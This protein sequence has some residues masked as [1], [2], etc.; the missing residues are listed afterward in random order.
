VNGFPRSELG[1]R[2]EKEAIDKSQCVIL[3]CLDNHQRQQQQQQLKSER[4]DLHHRSCCR[5]DC[6][7]SLINYEIAVTLRQDAKR[8]RRGTVCRLPRH[9]VRTTASKLRRVVFRQLGF[10]FIVQH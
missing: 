10:R 3:P 7:A 2:G 8:A 1:V 9:T 6:D 4:H 5:C